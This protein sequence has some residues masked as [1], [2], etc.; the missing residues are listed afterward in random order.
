M[1]VNMQTSSKQPK[2]GASPPIRSAEFA[3]CYLPPT[4]L[5]QQDPLSLVQSNVPNSPSP[6]KSF[7]FDC[8]KEQVGKN[9]DEQEEQVKREQEQA[10]RQ[11]PNSTRQRFSLF[12]KRFL[13]RSS[14][15]QLSSNGNMGVK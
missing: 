6:I 9:G 2:H 10:D 5:A 12:F 3:Q 14:T 1:W 8:W 13:T 15:M 7:E 11:V 4:W